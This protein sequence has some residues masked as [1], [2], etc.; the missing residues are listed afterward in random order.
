MLPFRKLIMTGLL[1][2]AGCSSPADA[3]AGVM[4]ELDVFSGLP[5][6]TWTLSRREAE[7][8]G[9]RFTGLSEARGAALPDPVLGYRGFWITSSEGGAIPE[10]AYVAGD[11]V[12][13]EYGGAKTLY[14]D[15]KQIEEWLRANAS[16]RGY[17]GV[18]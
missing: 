6:P 14:R 8:L 9:R 3:P 4:V 7:E 13:V 11:L 12:L 18:F 2:L 1:A 17:A 15:E 16:R 5:N 10:R